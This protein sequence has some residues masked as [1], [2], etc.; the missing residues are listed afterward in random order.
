ME[1][2]PFDDIQPNVQRLIQYMQRRN[3][4][5]DNQGIETIK[6]KEVIETIKDKEV[7]SIR[8][9][10]SDKTY[11]KTTY[12]FPYSVFTLKKYTPQIAWQTKKYTIEDAQQIGIYYGIV[13]EEIII[14]ASKLLEGL[15][16]AEVKGIRSIIGKVEGF[17]IIQFSEVKTT[18]NPT[19]AQGES[20]FTNT[21]TSYYIPYSVFESLDSPAEIWSSKISDLNSLKTPDNTD[22][23]F[24]TH[25][26][27]GGKRKP[28]DKCTVAELKKKARDIIAKY[29]AKGKKCTY[30]KGYSSMNKSELIA[31]LRRKK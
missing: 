26:A 2:I 23:D 3:N 24:S 20:F 8:I 14:K 6:D 21:T 7:I 22:L 1:S 4:N 17:K 28:L 18:F 5:P 13:P 11:I 10:D 31:A 12:Y 25:I 19:A 27:N 16:T 29:T 30:L 15:D 9:S